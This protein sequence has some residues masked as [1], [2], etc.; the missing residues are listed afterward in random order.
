MDVNKKGILKI[1]PSLLKELTV[2]GD[3]YKTTYNKKF[4]KRK[5]WEKPDNKK[6]TSF[7][8]GTIRQIFVKVG[9]QV[10][11]ND[12]LL[13]LEAMKMM[14]TIYATEDG[15]I[16]SVRVSEGDKLPKGIVML[17]FE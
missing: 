4:L 8:P 13:V 11:M 16:K 6:V 3:T 7:I 12:K 14:N 2:R 5:K 15:T 9:D 1:D 10:K 17:E